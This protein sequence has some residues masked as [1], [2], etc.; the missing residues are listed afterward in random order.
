MRFCE[1]PGSGFLLLARFQMSV[2][3]CSEERSELHSVCS[4][5]SMCGCA[6]CVARLDAL[7]L[8]GLGSQFDCL[9][10]FCYI[11]KASGS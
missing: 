7:G 2:V 8:A 5:C 1:V 9:A 11:M 4:V 3:V 10:L 6:L